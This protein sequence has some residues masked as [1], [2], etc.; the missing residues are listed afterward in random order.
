MNK[1]ILLILLTI[2][3][4]A[5]ID[6]TF[7]ESEKLFEPKQIVSVEFGMGV[8]Q[9]LQADTISG[10]SS[11]SRDNIFG[12]IKLGAE[13][14]GLRLFI[15]YRPMIIDSIFTHSFGLELDSLIDINNNFAFF[16]GLNGGGILYEIIDNN[17]GSDYTKDLTAYYGVETGFIYKISEKHELELGGRFSITN[18][19]SE[20]TNKSYI[21]DQLL[22]YYLAYN[23]K[24]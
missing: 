4:F 20:S 1:F 23:Y 5:D 8:V 14:I 7:Q 9:R 18:V 2:Q 6:I 11:I 19:N 3:T 21:F 17:S 12:G 16:Y 24:Y 22:N 15:S 10:S 13:D